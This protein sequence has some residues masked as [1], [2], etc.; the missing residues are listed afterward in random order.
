MDAS[1]ARNAIARRLYFAQMR[2][3]V[4]LVVKKPTMPCTTEFGAGGLL[5]GNARA[6]GPGAA[7][8][9]D[10]SSFASDK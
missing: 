2:N 5:G 7:L 6:A 9:P 3:F 4:K 10:I 1:N 8:W